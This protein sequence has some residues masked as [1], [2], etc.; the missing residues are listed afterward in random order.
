MNN[1][2]EKLNFSEADFK[3]LN[4]GL[5]FLP[6]KDLSGELMIGIL[7][8]IM[9]K[10]DPDA[11]A[12]MDYDRKQE[13]IKSERAKALMIEE[14]RILQGKILMLQRFLRTNGLLKE[15]HSYLND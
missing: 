15:A 14:I 13:R 2:I 1:E 3:L 5:E 11:K 12:K 10:D 7:S 8:S 6:S 4:E 9:A